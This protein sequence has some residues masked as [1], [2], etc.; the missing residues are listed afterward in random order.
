MPKTNL[1]VQMWHTRP[2]ITTTSW[3]GL[4]CKVR[5]CLGLVTN[6][7]EVV[8][9]RWFTEAAVNEMAA[10]IAAFVHFAIVAGGSDTAP[11]T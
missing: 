10:S 7:L 2:R 5:Y 11:G 8:E 6:D 9:T 4:W 3:D 1:G